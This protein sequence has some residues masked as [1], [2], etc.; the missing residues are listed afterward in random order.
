MTDRLWECVFVC[1]QRD[2]AGGCMLHA[3]SISMHLCVATCCYRLL[4]PACSYSPCLKR[5]DPKLNRNA[6]EN[7][8][9]N[10]ENISLVSFRKAHLKRNLSRL[11]IH[12]AQKHAFMVQR[13]MHLVHSFPWLFR[14]P[15]RVS[16]WRERAASRA[17]SWAK[18]LSLFCKRDL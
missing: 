16:S 15:F 6:L 1:R 8:N 11:C 2:F 17:V 13:K 9:R 10:P 3:A 18:I 4:H 12:R 14:W 7:T 5:W